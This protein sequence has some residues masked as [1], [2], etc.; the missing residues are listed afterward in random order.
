[1]STDELKLRIFTDPER[2]RGL[3]EKIDIAVSKAEDGN[4]SVAASALFQSLQEICELLADT[5]TLYNAWWGLHRLTPLFDPLGCGTAPYIG[6]E[7]WLSAPFA[8]SCQA[9][10]VVGWTLRSDA[11]G[12]VVQHQGSGQMVVVAASECFATFAN[13]D[14]NRT[15]RLQEAAE[16]KAKRGIDEDNDDQAVPA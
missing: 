10:T 5:K 15:D 16:K 2:M 12:M 8:T 7:V 3:E 13:A 4:R 6:M 11:Q 9:A 14:L 1:M